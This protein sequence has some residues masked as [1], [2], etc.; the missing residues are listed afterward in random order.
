MN[1]KRFLTLLGICALSVFMV[2]SCT[3]AQMGGD[4]SKIEG[5]W[6]FT[7]E[8]AQLLQDGKV[9]EEEVINAV[10][11]EALN[12]YFEFF[13]NGTFNALGTMPGEDDVAGSGTYS[14]FDNRLV[15]T[16]SAGSDMETMSL[17]IDSVNSKQ[18]VLKQED[19]QY[20][21]GGVKY[22]VSVKMYFEK[23]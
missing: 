12:F 14:V 17:L 10:S 1:M 19:E 13:A 20:Y 21:E 15:L 5:K 3:P 8:V 11:V 2:F 18:L 16:Y 6:K 4:D 9:V 7:K 22:V 23:M